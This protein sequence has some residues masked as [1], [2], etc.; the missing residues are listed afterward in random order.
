MQ[1]EVIFAN[2]IAMQY[3]LKNLSRLEVLVSE[4]CLPAAQ[5]MWLPNTKQKGRGRLTGCLERAQE[6]G[7]KVQRL[8]TD[9]ITSVYLEQ[10]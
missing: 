6:V 3:T 7:S 1:R 9:R 2:C 5:N 8:L 10:G 4:E